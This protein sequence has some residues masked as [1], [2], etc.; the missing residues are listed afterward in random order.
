MATAAQTV[1]KKW[2]SPGRT[3][4]GTFSR[5]LGTLKN[6]A[7]QAEAI[8]T[9][10]DAAIRQSAG[11]TG[12]DASRWALES[13]HLEVDAV[14]RE[15]RG[16]KGRIVPKG[17]TVRRHGSEHTVTAAKGQT[18]KQI[19]AA[20]KKAPK[21][22]AATAPARPPAL[23]PAKAQ[24]PK[25]WQVEPS[26]QTVTTGVKASAK[27]D[28]IPML[29]NLPA[30]MGGP[31]WKKFF[32]RHAGEDLD[33]ETNIVHLGDDFF[34]AFL[35]GEQIQGP[36][37]GKDNV[38]GWTMV[39][40]IADAPGGELALDAHAMHND[41]YVASWY[42]V[43]APR[44]P[45][46]KDDMALKMVTASAIDGARRALTVIAKRYGATLP[47][48]REAFKPS[49]RAYH[50]QIAAKHGADLRGAPLYAEVDWSRKV[51]VNPND[52]FFGSF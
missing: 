26:R 16:K 14:A 38:G 8:I 12:P 25:P 27:I 49:P 44:D 28:R 10:V 35:G 1:N 42:A 18:V 46:E 40:R 41:S 21:K 11:A 47:A 9:K 29:E 23:F 50:A 45:L 39:Y 17:V 4:V 15:L 32:K 7:P 34:P 31:A 37:T 3:P 13:W 33:A 22:H 24:R 5:W 19:A 43:I 51:A 48:S 2:V 6:P 20:L 30:S 52:D 36:K